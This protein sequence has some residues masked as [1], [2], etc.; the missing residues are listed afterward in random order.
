MLVFPASARIFREALRE[1]YVADL[2]KAGAVAMNSGD[3]VEVAGDKVVNKTTGRSF[4]T[5]PLPKARQAIID[6]GGLIAY[7][8]QRVMET[9]ARG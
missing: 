1:G 5:V 4:T 8:R 9:A 2:M 3:D 7:T 6:A